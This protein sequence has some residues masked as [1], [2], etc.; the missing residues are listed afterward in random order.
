MKAIILAA[1]KGERLGKITKLLPKPM[2][3]L[4][5][6]PILEHN[7]KL[8]KKYYI[9][10]IYLNLYHLPDKI[11]KY[12]K[13]GSELGVSIKYSL[14]NTLL[15]TASG[16]KKILE[17]FGNFNDN[18]FVIYGDNYSNY[19][20]NELIKKS[21]ETNSIVTIAFHYRENIQNSG[22]AEFDENNR[23]LSFIE[24]PKKNESKSR[25]VNAGIYYFR[26]DIIDYIPK[27]YSD[28]SL[29]IFPKLIKENIPIYGVCGNHFVKSVDTI[30]MLNKNSKILYK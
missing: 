25:W 3:K 26:S 10:D 29:D 22:V 17:E 2:I 1:G 23:I 21:K 13:D 5:G 20:L 14:E 4:D 11:I 12:F 19:D 27:G 15:G 18:F 7:I 9:H 6:K 28:F 30:E 8:C 16:V 24:K